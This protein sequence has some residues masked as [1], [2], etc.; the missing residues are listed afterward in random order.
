MLVRN[1]LI[2]VLQSDWVSPGLC[3][4]KLLNMSFTN[5][6]HSEN[7]VLPDGASVLAGAL[8]SDKAREDQ[9]RVGTLFIEEGA[10]VPD[11]LMFENETYLNGW[12]SVNNLKGYELDRKVREAG[13]TLFDLAQIKASVFCIDTEKGVHRAIRRIL[14]QTKLDNFNAL[15]ISQV[16]VKHFLGLPYVTVRAHTRHVQESMFLLHDKRLAKRN[17]AKLALSR[18]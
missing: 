4:R 11:S 7:K 8:P 13:W 15:E 12:R 5:Y 17:K 1:R 2:S 10:P 6:S 18:A 9:I 3:I 14:T 16:T